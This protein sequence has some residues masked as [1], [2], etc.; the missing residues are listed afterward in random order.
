MF[1]GFMRRRKK[2]G[3]RTE[4]KERLENMLSTRRRVVPISN[5]IDEKH[6][7]NSVNEMENVVREL[8]AK[9]FNVAKHNVRVECEEH[10]GYV[11]II[12]NITF[13]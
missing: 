8:A 5:F 11:V 9:Y 13:D 12:T 6:F 3:S 1:F 2:K 4:A 10:N 7:R